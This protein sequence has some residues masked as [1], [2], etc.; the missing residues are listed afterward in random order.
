[1]SYAGF[2]IE[3]RG[4]YWIARR[5]TKEGIYQLAPKKSLRE[6]RASIDAH[7]AQLTWEELIAA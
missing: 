3:H 2:S 7:N 4:V 5:R 6:I 1:M